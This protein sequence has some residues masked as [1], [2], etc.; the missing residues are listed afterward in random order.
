VTREGEPGHGQR[1]PHWR[2]DRDRLVAARV[3]TLRVVILGLAALIGW[4][5]LAAPSAAAAQDSGALTIFFLNVGQADA[6]LLDAP[7][8]SVAL[9][10]AGDTPSG[11]DLVRFLGDRAVSRID[12]WVPSHPHADHV[13]GFTAVLNAGVPVSHALLPTPQYNT[14]TL[15]RQLGLLLS[16]GVD[17]QNAAAG[18]TLALDR[19]GQVTAEVLNPTEPPET[20]DV[21]ENSLVLLVNF[22]HTYFLFAGDIGTRTEARVVAR[23]LGSSGTWPPIDVLKVP[24]HGSAGS[25]SMPF[26]NVIRPR[27]AVVSV[28]ARNS[29]GHPTA[30]ALDRLT[31][32]GAEILRTDRL[33]TIVATSDGTTVTVETAPYIH[34]GVPEP[35]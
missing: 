8:G 7:D 31:A 30:A 9:V 2:L 19:A 6:A 23:R 3:L 4:L 17:V 15:V 35:P 12:W 29:Y 25:S 18:Q 32:V 27:F 34:L 24:H 20:N 5:D 1:R 10:D 22:G 28:G 21:N 33:G 26:L 13:G 14:P 16:S 11:P